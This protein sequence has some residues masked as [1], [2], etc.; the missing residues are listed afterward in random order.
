[1]VLAASLAVACGAKSELDTAFDGT[2]S[3]SAADAG[4]G[5]G[6]GVVLDAST[7]DPCEG[8]DCEP[9][10]SPAC[11]N[12]T[13][14]APPPPTCG[15]I[16]SVRSFDAGKC[17]ANGTCT[18]R[19]TD[20][21]CRYGCA[22]GA[23]VARMVVQGTQSTCTVTDDGAAKCWGLNGYQDL[24]S[25]TFM[26]LYSLSPIDVTG[27]GSGVRE[28]ASDSYQACAL[29][30]AGAVSCWGWS[31]YGV[32]RGPRAI[33]GVQSDIVQVSAG[34]ITNCALTSAGAVKCW[35][36][37]DPSVVA[38]VVPGLESGVA[39]VSAKSYSPCVVTT[40]GGVKCW[41]GNGNG[42]LGNGT[43]VDSATPVDVVGLDRGVR[44]VTTDA[45]GACAL[46]VQGGVKC[47]GYNIYAGLGQG[48]AGHDPVP[49]DVPGLA[50]G[51][52]QVSAGTFFA[53]ALL[54]TG[55]VKCWG[56]NMFGSLGDGTFTT[57][58]SARDVIGLPADVIAISAGNRAACAMTASGDIWCWGDDGSGQLGD[59]SLTNSPVPVKVK[60]L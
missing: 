25:T 38:A 46:T 49:V 56:F 16:V 23:C 15:T 3:P 52:A 22:N 26:G 40:N 58:T 27:M 7:I 1:M 4:R 10:P 9:P 60:G 13:C 28:V 12:V 2:S 20:T 5:R 32:W 6:G 53:C 34:G 18:Y 11:V 41:G 29:T 39:Q 30:N 55:G 17:G 21:P 48:T 45:Y 35:P 31:R 44:A 8:G 57:R 51:V 37:G 54:Y 43:F 33:A 19:V 24:G 14:D 47:W 59:G 50:S 42:E 36:I